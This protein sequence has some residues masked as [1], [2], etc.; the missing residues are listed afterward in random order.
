MIREAN[1]RERY[2]NRRRVSRTCAKKR[3]RHI[4]LVRKEE[5]QNVMPFGRGA[6]A[7]IAAFAVKV[8][9]CIS[10]DIVNTV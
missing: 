1:K 8:V 9:A 3:E 6:F 7:R 4:Y 10:T 5:A 2:G